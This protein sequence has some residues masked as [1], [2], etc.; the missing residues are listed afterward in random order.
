MSDLFERILLLKQSLIFSGV[1]SDGLR[2]VAQMLEEENY[3]AGDRIYGVF[4]NGGHIFILQSGRIGVSL[5][6]S[7]SRN[8]STAEIG[9]GECFGEMNL[10]DE[11]PR[12]TSA[13]V[14]EDSIV[15][16]LEKSSLRNLIIDHP[17][18]SIG[19]IQ[20]LSLRLRTANLKNIKQKI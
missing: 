11:L 13:Y 4:D 12:T 5:I 10:L 2:V 3:F 16:S 18:L 19:M 17:E 7:D 1:S 14:L 15:L 6:P 8:K 20:G 9:P